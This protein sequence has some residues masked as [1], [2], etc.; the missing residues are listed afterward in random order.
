MK[1]TRINVVKIIFCAIVMISC[2]NNTANKENL[3]AEM[4][5]NCE[6][7]TLRRMS[8]VGKLYEGDRGVNFSLEPTSNIS[9]IFPSG[10]NIRLLLFDVVQGEWMEIKDNVEYF[11]VDGKH[12]VGKND[13]TKEYDYDLIGVIP[14]FGKKAAL[15]IVLHGN[16]YE[17]GIETDKCT[18]AY[19]DFEFIP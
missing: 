6:M 4:Y 3:F 17:N 1:T 15:R 11:P 7:N 9:V 12:I 19:I 2:T 18:G 5:A 16:V 14:S 8:Y 10:S 13:P